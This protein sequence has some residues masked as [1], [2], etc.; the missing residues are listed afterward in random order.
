MSWFFFHIFQ[1]YI[2]PTQRL[3]GSGIIQ[4]AKWK[5]ADGK[6]IRICD[7]KDD[8]LYNSLCF[9]QRWCN[10]RRGKHEFE[11]SV[12][13]LF[14]CLLE[15]AEERGIVEKMDIKVMGIKKFKFIERDE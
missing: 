1:A 7:M 2:F 13:P 3:S 15:E 9:V 5:M 12:R 14:W 11:D 6:T 8:H 10:E 4:T